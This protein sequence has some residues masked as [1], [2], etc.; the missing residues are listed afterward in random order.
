MSGEAFS[1]SAVLPEAVL[2]AELAFAVEASRPARTAG[3]Q[4]TA[5]LLLIDIEMKGLAT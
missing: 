1:A 3:D 5:V 4:P 2:A